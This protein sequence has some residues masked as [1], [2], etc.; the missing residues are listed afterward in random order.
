MRLGKVVS[1][2]WILQVWELKFDYH[3]SSGNQGTTDPSS[4]GYRGCHA[5]VFERILARYKRPSE[6][7]EKRYPFPNQGN[8]HGVVL[9]VSISC[10]LL[11]PALLYEVEHGTSGNRGNRGCSNK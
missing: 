7:S 3:T 8:G 11:A 5:C 2:N 1:R 4:L 6:R 9:I 10:L